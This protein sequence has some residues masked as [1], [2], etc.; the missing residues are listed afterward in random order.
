[1]TFYE[2]A[3]RVLEEAGMPLHSTDITKRAVDKGLLSHVGK[4]PEVTMLSRLAAMAKRSR[5]RKLQVT[6]RDTFALTD[7]MLPEDPE[8][9]T[10]TGVMEPN[11]EEALAPY[12]PSER[13]PEAHAEYLRS[14]GRQSDRK[15]R[16]DDRKKKYPPIAEVACEVLQECQTALV[17]SELLARMKAREGASD[18]LPISKLID[19]LAIDNQKRLDDGRKPLFSAARGESN[20]LQISLEPQAEGGPAPLEVQQAFCAACNLPFENGRVVLRSEQREKQQQQQPHVG[21][22]GV[23]APPAAEDVALFQTARHA[24]KDA[25]KA[26]ARI[27]RKKLSDLDLGTFEKASVRMLHGLHFR[28]LKVAR[29]SKDGPL[30]TARRREGSLEIRYAVRLLKGGGPVDRKHVQELRRELQQTGANVGLLL[31][32]G[33][34]RGDARS[35]C[36]AGPLVMLWA[37]DALADKFFEAKVGVSVTTIELYDI[38]EAFFAQAKLDADESTKRREERQKDRDQRGPSSDGEPAD[39]SEVSSS[40]ADAASPVTIPEGLPAVQQAEG[41]EGADEEDDGEEGEEE[42]EE[43]AEKSGDP[44]AP[45][46]PGEGK[47][48]RRRRRR[49]RGGAAVAGAPTAPGGE[50]PAASASAPAAAPAPEAAEAAPAPAP[51]EAPAEAPAPPSSEPG[52]TT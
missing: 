33:E 15:R 23:V 52:P 46:A 7:W 42:G 38:D 20:E 13:H 43:G 35:E 17:A 47:R 11:P 39:R 12:R 1:M 19:G 51:A 18:D 2:A 40:Q 14:I 48:R 44:A 37:G 25:R 28:E 21:A 34:A 41:A 29:R 36:T 50:A 6:V 24:G 5:D 31:T 8:A 49:R 4:T 27:L 26:M 10:T 30:M 45:G 9:L 16:D 32:A 3:L 22:P